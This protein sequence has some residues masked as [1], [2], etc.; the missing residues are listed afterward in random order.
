MI[1]GPL[2]RLVPEVTGPALWV[3]L[4]VAGVALIAI[5]TGLERGRERVAAAMRRLDTLTEGWE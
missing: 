1:G 4:A 2:A 3:V 5:A